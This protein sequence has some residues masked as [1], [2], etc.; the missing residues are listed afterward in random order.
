MSD[1]NI[2]KIINLLTWAI[3]VAGAINWGLEAFGYN[4][5]TKFLGVYPTAVNAV[6]MVIAACGVYQIIDK[7]ME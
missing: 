2:M 5:V 1:F 4:L 3:V 7:F 6:Y